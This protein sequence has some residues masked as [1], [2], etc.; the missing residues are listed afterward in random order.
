MVLHLLPEQF[1]CF[2]VVGIIEAIRIAGAYPVLQAVFNGLHVHP[3]VLGKLLEVFRGGVELGPYGYHDAPVHLMDFIY[4]ALRVGETGL[5]K[6]MA[7]P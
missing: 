2:G 3:A 4:H 7:T 5:V 1:P 6:L